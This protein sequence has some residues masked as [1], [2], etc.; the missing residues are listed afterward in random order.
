[1]KTVIN[2]EEGYAYIIMCIEW[3]NMV[4]LSL[5]TVVPYAT[6]FLIAVSFILTTV[7]QLISRALISHFI[8]WDKYRIMRK[9]MSEY[10]KA[11]MAA[12]RAGD[13]KQIEKLKKRKSQIDAMSAQ[14]MKPNMINMVI[15][16]VLFMVIWRVFL[17]PMF[18]SAGYSS[19]GSTFF[20][21]MFG[22]APVAFLPGNGLPLF[23]LYSCFSFFFS[24]I[25][26]RV[27]GSLPIE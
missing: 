13:T 9:E 22:G 7:N 1:M 23:I 16:L 14:Q 6:V 5:L 4:D 26:Q 27:L 11:N 18:T 10:Q 3:M 15:S 24:I 8:G 12:V 19:S 2:E 17:L 25:M 20:G 21:G